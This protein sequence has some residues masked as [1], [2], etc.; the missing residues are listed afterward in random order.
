M[1]RRDR[2][3]RV[4]FF[5]AV[6]VACLGCGAPR[7]S[8]PADRAPVT[9]G[10][11]QEPPATAPRAI[12]APEPPPAEP[13]PEPDLPDTIRTDDIPAGDECLEQLVK[14]GVPHR[15]LDGKGRPVVRTPVV[16]NGRLGGLR[17]WATGGVP[18]IADCR[19]LVALHRLAPHLRRIGV[20]GVRYSGAYVHRRAKA[21]GRLSLHAYG[22]AIDVH[23]FEFEQGHESVKRDFVRGRTCDLGESPDEQRVQRASVEASGEQQLAEAGSGPG[24]GRGVR[25]LPTDS[26]T[27]RGGPPRLN[28]VHC[29]VSSTGV[30]AQILTPDSD[31]HHHDH[32]H[33]GIARLE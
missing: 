1:V 27:K 19:L 33:W 2:W 15:A 22:L 21:T 20:V 13:P 4:G 17:M 16:L 12:A 23:E 31:R 14:L 25:A 5:V 32:F 10:Q 30:F 26:S 11:P 18:L 6:L 9:V 24:P 28:R 3:R 29:V 7:H 8:P